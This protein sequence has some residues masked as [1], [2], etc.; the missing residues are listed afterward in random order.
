MPNISK[1]RCQFMKSKVIGCFATAFVPGSI[2]NDFTS[3]P[4]M[5]VSSGRRG[6][7][8]LFRPNAGLKPSGGGLT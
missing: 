7:A 8:E 6:G 4:G 3:F 1:P 5:L 2:E